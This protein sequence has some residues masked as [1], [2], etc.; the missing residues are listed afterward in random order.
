MKLVL[1]V[2]TVVPETL[3]KNQGYT[4]S[5]LNADNC[6]NQLKQKTV[7]IQSPELKDFFR[8]IGLRIFLFN[9]I[10]TILIFNQYSQSP[11][12]RGIIITFCYKCGKESS[13][14]TY[15]CPR[16]GEKI[17]RSKAE[18]S[19][20]RRGRSNWEQE[21]EKTLSTIGKSIEE[22]IE[23]VIESI[24]EATKRETVI[25]SNCSEKNI[26]NAKFCYRCGKDLTQ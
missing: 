23:N 19:S 3:T 20:P 8:R 7:Q 14:N 5:I 25:C 11:G 6:L 24:Q 17:R 26:G 9:E 18:V 22:A 4:Q 13:E 10:Y 12:R 2:L 15:Y 21:I 16:C 1:N